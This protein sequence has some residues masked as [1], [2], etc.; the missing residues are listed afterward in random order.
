MKAN[1]KL[2]K[3]LE[4]NNKYINDADGCL[5][6]GDYVQASE[7]L[8]GATVTITKAIASQRKKTIKT[9][10]GIKFFL[11]QIA[12]ELKDESI[13]NIVLIA[14]ALH[15]NFYENSVHPDTVKKGAKTIKQFVKRMRNRFNFN[16]QQN[17]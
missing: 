1:G 17:S 4:L 10:E 6:K 16:E 13:N 11:A 3:Y 7:K 15:Q 12:R 5:K 9:H 8:W 14:D 2:K